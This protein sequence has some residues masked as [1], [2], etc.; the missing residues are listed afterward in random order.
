MSG[1]SEELDSLQR[2]ILRTLAND[3][4]APS[5]LL[6][7][8]SGHMSKETM[9]KNLRI[10]A[11]KGII[12]RNVD[13]SFR[14]PRV[15]YRAHQPHEG[16]FENSYPPNVTGRSK[17]TISLTNKE[18]A[19]FQRLLESMYLFLLVDQ[20]PNGG[21]GKSINPELR[22]RYSPEKGEGSISSTSFAMKGILSFTG[23][24]HH[25]AIKRARQFLAEHRKANGSYGPLASLSV[26]ESKYTITENCRHTAAATMASIELNDQTDSE[27][28]QSIHFLLGHQ[29]PDGGWGITSDLNIEDSDCITTAQVL[30]TLLLWVERGMKGNLDFGLVH[31]KILRGIG[32]LCEMQKGGFWI[33]DHNETNKTQYT[34]F[35]LFMVPELERYAPL[36]YERASMQLTDICKRSKGVPSSK[37]G[38]PHVGTTT[39]FILAMNFGSSVNKHIVSEAIRNVLEFYDEGESLLPIESLTSALVLE[40]TRIEGLNIIPPKETISK[41]DQVSADIVHKEEEIKNGQIRLS[42]ILPSKYAFLEKALTTSIKR[43]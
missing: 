14:P 11:E 30:R 36:I 13:E 26:Y 38:S 4:L 8:L 40:L 33:Y 10:L 35:V 41:L 39:A 18:V 43:I 21:W 7:R 16:R 32:W 15:Y 12:Q 34:P 20:L 3:Q 1:T 19:R 24:S 2:T 23:N 29:K 22:K 17:E 6:K 37:G 27:I 31:A 42:N 25:S 28:V 9:F 5:E